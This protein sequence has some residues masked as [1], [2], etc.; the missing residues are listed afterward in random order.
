MDVEPLPAVVDPEQAV[1]P[2]AP[3]VHDDFDDNVM[4]HLYGP[5]HP[6]SLTL[7]GLTDELFRQAD[8]S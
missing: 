8:K 1:Q 7:L 4:F 2:G 5:A 3:K 6:P